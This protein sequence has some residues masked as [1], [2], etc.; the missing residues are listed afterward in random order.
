MRCCTMIMVPLILSFVPA[1]ENV[2]LNFLAVGDWGGAETSPYTTD[3]ETH[4]AKQMAQTANQTQ[5]KFVLAL[6]KAERNEFCG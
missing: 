6:G 4:T 2:G 3:I 1:V 5:A